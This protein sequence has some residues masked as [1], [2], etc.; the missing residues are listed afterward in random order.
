MLPDCTFTDVFLLI[1]IIVTASTIR[2]VSSTR[3]NTP[4][5]PPAIIAL[6]LLAELESNC[7]CSK[8]EDTILSVGSVVTVCVCDQM[9]IFLKPYKSKTSVIYEKSCTY[10]IYMYCDSK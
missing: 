7:E 10:T 5:T 3:R 4:L 1:T 2:S 6:L 8:D 9:R